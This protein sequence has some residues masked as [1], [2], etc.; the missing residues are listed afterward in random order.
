M[1]KRRGKQMKKVSKCGG[2]RNVWLRVRKGG[3]EN[4]E[5]KTEGK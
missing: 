1:K 3:R 4:R 5:K 2:G